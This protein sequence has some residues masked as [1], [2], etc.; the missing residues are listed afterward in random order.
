[1]A[2]QLK[3]ICT[4]GVH[5]LVNVNLDITVRKKIFLQILQTVFVPTQPPVQ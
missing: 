4:Y 3:T 5:V 2:V 1:M